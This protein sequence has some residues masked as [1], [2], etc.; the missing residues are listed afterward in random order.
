MRNLIEPHHKLDD[1]L[2]IVRYELN[3]ACTVK[4]HPF[5][6]VVLSTCGNDTVKSRYL[7]LRKVLEN[8]S[9]LIFTDARSCKITDLRDNNICNL[10]FYHP[11]KS[12][13]VC[14]SGKAAIHNNNSVSKQYWYGVKNHSFRSYT[15]VL[16]PGTKIDEIAQGYD[17]DEEIGDTHFTVI[18]IIP[19]AIEVLQLNRDHHIRALFNFTENNQQATFLA[20]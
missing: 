19:T 17:W 7:V 20:P 16:A 14:V 18:E 1:I 10:L 4:R 6:Y 15:T 8:D 11:G 9:F 5:K 2:S 3:K 12:L 13:Q